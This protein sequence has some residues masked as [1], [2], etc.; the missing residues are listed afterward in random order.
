MDI[1]VNG[2]KSI[3]NYINVKENLIF[4]KKVL[5]WQ[6]AKKKNHYKGESAAKSTY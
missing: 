4:L 5:V 3:N 2:E 6:K 1:S